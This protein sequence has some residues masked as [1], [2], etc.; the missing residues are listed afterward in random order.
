MVVQQCIHTLG[1]K[2]PLLPHD[3]DLLTW[4]WK[5]QPQTSKDKNDGSQ[6]L[7]VLLGVAQCI[8]MY[9]S[10][11]LES[12]EIHRSIGS[13][14]CGPWAP[15][16][17]HPDV[18][19]SISSSL[20]VVQVSKSIKITEILFH[21]GRNGNCT[22]SWH[23]TWANTSNDLPLQFLHPTDQSL[24]CKPNPPGALTS[25]LTWAEQLQE[26]K[27]KKSQNLCELLPYMYNDIYIYIWISN[28]F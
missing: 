27:R 9:K 22:S 2:M 26:K 5:S 20:E 23:Q 25:G 19:N 1:R 3:H 28:V 15:T 4:S 17:K 18:Q 16:T 10:V 13:I 14:A 8:S 21:K 7:E 6:L 11:S 12:L 24:G